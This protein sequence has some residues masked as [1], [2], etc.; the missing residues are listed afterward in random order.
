M[1]TC[2]VTWGPCPSITG[3]K[4]PVIILSPEQIARAPHITCGKRKLKEK[5]KGKSNEE[6]ATVKSHVISWISL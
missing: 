2:R 4:D 5:N 1:P 6:K 3:R